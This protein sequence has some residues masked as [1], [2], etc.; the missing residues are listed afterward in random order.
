MH[1]PFTMAVS[2][3]DG[4]AEADGEGEA[5]AAGD[6][7]AVGLCLELPPNTPAA[8]AEPI[9]TPTTSTAAM[10]LTDICLTRRSRSTCRCCRRSWASRASRRW[11]SFFVATGAV[12]SS[13]RLPGGRPPG[14]ALR[15]FANRTVVMGVVAPVL[16]VRRTNRVQAVS[17]PAHDQASARFSITWA[18]LL[19]LAPRTGRTKC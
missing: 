12:L 1:L 10:T 13:C 16:S 3:V 14:S 19:T 17:L 11:R 5:D 18:Q 7:P 9:P 6:A 8:K 15:N 4:L 2:G